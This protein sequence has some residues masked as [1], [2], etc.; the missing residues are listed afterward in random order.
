MHPVHWKVV[1]LLCRRYGDDGCLRIE[2][3]GPKQ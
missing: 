2:R 1:G 3:F